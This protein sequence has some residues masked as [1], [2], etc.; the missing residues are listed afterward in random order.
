MAPELV[1]AF[2][3]NVE[4]VFLAEGPRVLVERPVL[5]ALGTRTVVGAHQDH[6][7]VEDS[8][9]FE[10]GDD[11]TDLMVGVRQ[12][13]GEH[14]HLARVQALFRL[15]KVGP[16][17]EAVGSL[18]ELGVRGNDP[19]GALTLEH[20]ARH[21]S[22]PSSKRPRYRSIQSGGAW[23]G[24]CIAPVAKYRKNGWCGVDCC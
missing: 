21:S 4:V 16:P 17:R 12:E 19:L 13:P 3:R 14:F 9:R 22:H 11:P 24:A 18:G 5:A 8:E 6:G 15:R 7:V 2:E 10:R 23:C 1:D 20:P